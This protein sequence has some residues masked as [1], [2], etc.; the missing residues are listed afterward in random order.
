MKTITLLHPFSA[1]AIG[2]KESDLYYYHSKP[3]ENALRKIQTEGYKIKVEYFTAIF[4][5]YKK[6]IE[7]ISKI[8]WPITKPIFKHRHGWRKQH[9]FFHYFY[10]IITPPDVTIINMSGHGSPYVFKLAKLLRRKQKPY[11]AMIGGIN[12]SYSSEA[13]NYYKSANHVIVHTNYQKN[14]L[15]KHYG[16]KDTVLEVIP[17]GVD[18]SVFKPLKIAKEETEL[19]YVGRI[20][21]LKQI[22]KIIESLNFLVHTKKEYVTLNIIGP[23]SDIRYLKELKSL[24]SQY[25]LSPQVKFKGSLSQEQLIP[26]YQKATLLL[27]PS[28][29]ESFGMVMVEAMACGTPVIALKGSGGPDEIV[30]NAING[31]LCTDE[32]FKH[33]IYDVITSKELLLELSINSRKLVEKKWSLAVTTE[34]FRKMLHRVFKDSHDKN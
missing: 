3:H 10:N 15:K 5:P 8:F 11:I 30:E 13:L 20:S 32:S 14:N 2:L 4:F 21:R 16:F 9:S 28:K 26:F 22:E 18:I 6:N 33:R 31:F 34:C 25:R 17:L 27:L 1:K 12:M 19:L 29:H 7:Y 24:V 23:E